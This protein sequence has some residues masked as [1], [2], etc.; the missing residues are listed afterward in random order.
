MVTYTNISNKTLS[1]A[2]VENVSGDN[3][4][5]YFSKSMQ[6]SGNGDGLNY[7]DITLRHK[8]S[9][10]TVTLDATST[11]NNITA[12]SGVSISPHNSYAKMLLADGTTTVQGTSGTRNIVFSTLNTPVITAAPV[13]VNSD[14]NGS[15]TIASVT[16]QTTG[17]V[18]PT[19][20]H[21]NITF[22]NLKLNRG[23]KYTLKLSFT[24]NDQYLTY[25]GYPAVR[26]NG[27][28]WMRHNLG[29]DI[30]ADPDVPS[31]NTIGNYYQ[32][33]RSKVVATAS[34]PAGPISG[35]DNTTIPANN[36]WN[37]GTENTPVK[38]GNDPCPVGWR[39]PSMNEIRILFNAS[40]VTYSTTTTSSG[41]PAYSAEVYKSYRNPSIK[42]TIP[43]GGSRQ[44]T[45]GH[46]VMRGQQGLYSTNT[47]A[48][49]T[50]SW[51]AQFLSG[52][53]FVNFIGQNNFGGLS[54]RCIAES[55][56]Q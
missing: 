21:Q 49:T 11:N 50:S 7:L 17:S 19:V 27:F 35:W 1:T 38:T 34:T 45:D 22:N 24:P 29:A 44:W 32:W 18:Q 31:L 55:P 37:N 2:S 53:G 8:F 10:V 30:S 28:I 14:S 47:K 56:L 51:E 52:S 20:T 12:I 43:L 41:T 39:V 25:K 23:M 26:I 16:M 33:G 46:L 6:V 15:F 9:E 4:L 42:I 13:Y 54:V 48:G 36:A 40:N 5:M 3:D